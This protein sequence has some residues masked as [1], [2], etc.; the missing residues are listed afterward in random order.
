MF[1]KIYKSLYSGSMIGS[2]ACVF[3]VMGYVIANQKPAKDGNFYVELN[4]KLIAFIIGENERFVQEAIRKLCR[5]DPHTTTPDEEGKRL[6]KTGQ[7]FYLVVNGKKYNQITNEDRRREQ[8]RISQQTF[9]DKN[10]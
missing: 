1:G 2:G 10:K 8:N 6:I 4:P 7:Y 3:A 9:R 5:P